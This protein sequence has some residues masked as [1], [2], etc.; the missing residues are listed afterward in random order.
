MDG[1]I[2]AD[3]CLDIADGS[4]LLSMTKMSVGVELVLRLR[5]ISSTLVA[6]P[7]DVITIANFIVFS[8]PHSKFMA[9]TVVLVIHPLVKS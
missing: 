3:V 8:T 4:P 9:A 1:E 7:A 6:H 5:T 2:H